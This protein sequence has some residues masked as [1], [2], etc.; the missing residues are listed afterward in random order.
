[1]PNSMTVSGSNIELTMPDNSTQVLQAGVIVRFYFNDAEGQLVAYL[2]N[3]V[4]VEQSG[5][6]LLQNTTLG[7]C[8][9]V[10]SP[11]GSLPANGWPVKVEVALDEVGEYWTQVVPTSEDDVEGIVWTPN[12]HFTIASMVAL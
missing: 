2:G 7:N 6:M 3:K 11:C 12:T 9:G 5:R 4:I 10:P 1:M 8:T